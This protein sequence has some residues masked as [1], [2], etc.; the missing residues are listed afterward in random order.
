MYINVRA[1][2]TWSRCSVCNVVYGNMNRVA[3]RLSLHTSCNCIN[4]NPK[5]L[6]GPYLTAST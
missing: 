3:S 6:A 4:Q 1:P 2:V 5:V